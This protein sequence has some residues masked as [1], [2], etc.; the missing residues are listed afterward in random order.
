ML[1]IS[2]HVQHVNNCNK[3][4]G[5]CLRGVKNITRPPLCNMSRVGMTHVAHVQTI[6]NA[7]LNRE[8]R[9]CSSDPP[10]HYGLPTVRFHFGASV[11]L[12]G[13]DFHFVWQ[14][15]GSWHW[16]GSGGA[17]G[18]RLAPWSP[19][20]FVWQAWHL[21]TSTSILCGRCGTC[22]VRPWLCAVGVAF[23]DINPHFVW[24]AWHLW[25]WAGSGGAVVAAAASVAGVALGDIQC[26]SHTALS[27]TAP[28]HTTLS[29][30]LTLWH[31]TFWHTILSLTTIYHHF[32]G[33]CRFSFL[34]FPSHFHICLVIIGR[35]WHVG[36]S[37]PLIFFICHYLL[38]VVLKC[39]FFQSP[40]FSL[41][42]SPCFTIGSFW[43]G[44]SNRDYDKPSTASVRPL[45]VRSRLKASESPTQALLQRSA[46]AV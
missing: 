15:W 17:I 13:I 18:S 4:H 40:Y 6:K 21:P 30:T 41:F 24:Q 2:G 14:A 8:K 33:P 37:G 31:T 42:I 16:A 25:P 36:A 7:T 5:P 20:L 44:V 35:S 29:H 34:P 10:A 45:T 22:W 32:S 11:A 38:L 9:E 3:F 23:G 28:S 39:S 12:G 26:P 19:R 1:T 46:F 27:H 43:G